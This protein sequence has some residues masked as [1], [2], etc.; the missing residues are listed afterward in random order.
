MES[1]MDIMRSRAAHDSSYLA[2]GTFLVHD[3]KPITP[4]QPK[5]Q[6]ALRKDIFTPLK[7]E[8]MFDPPSS[9]K[10][11]VP[12]PDQSLNS[13][14]SK[15]L[16]ATPERSVPFLFNG[17]DS[18]NA[19]PFTFSVK[20]SDRPN[21]VQHNC[22]DPQVD[23]SRL[24]LFQ[25]HYDTFTREHLSALVDAIP[26]SSSSLSA[27]SASIHDGIDSPSGLSHYRPAKRIKLSPPDL[28][29]ARRRHRLSIPRNA[30]TTGRRDNIRESKSVVQT[31]VY[32]RSPS[33][34]LSR[35]PPP[36]NKPLEREEDITEE[37]ENAGLEAQEKLKDVKQGGYS[38]LGFRR[39]AADSMAQIRR[40][41]RRNIS[42]MS[43]TAEISA[44]SIDTDPPPQCLEPR[45]TPISVPRVLVGTPCPH[46][47]RKLALRE[48]GVGSGPGSTFH[49][50]DRTAHLAAGANHLDPTNTRSRS[51]ALPYPSQA[52]PSRSTQG[53]SQPISTPSLAALPTASCAKHPG[54]PVAVVDV[55]KAASAN[56]NS[57]HMN[58]TA[59][60]SASGV[61]ITQIMPKDVP[62]LLE[63]LGDMVFNRRK[64]VWTKETE[65]DLNGNADS[66]E[67]SDDP[68]RDIE[69]L[70][71]E[72][73]D[74]VASPRRALETDAKGP[75]P[76]PLRSALK[77]GTPAS[78]ENTPH[79]F[80]VNRKAGVAPRRSVSFSDGRT[81][82][83]I[84]GLHDS[85]TDESQ[86]SQSSQPFPD[87][88]MSMHVPEVP[89]NDPSEPFET[90]ARA[91]RI[92]EMLECL[93]GDSVGT[94]Q[95]LFWVRES[96]LMGDRFV[97]HENLVH[98]SCRQPNARPGQTP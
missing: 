26:I 85:Q 92:A 70:V 7:L 35:T 22:N 32:A 64:M 42:P 98:S 38:F 62:E 1:M 11:Q 75:L 54:W 90:S 57:H 47:Q 81:S 36:F 16:D 67:T 83:R 31:I 6:K 21:P 20:R 9:Q 95:F 77:P 50:M 48:D 60:T 14:S 66:G 84:R 96:S 37:G 8:T 29:R 91:D 93:E 80:V 59:H 4:M 97:A 23:K 34:P 18:S 61:Q 39:Q 49:P 71:D 10:T 24:R 52:Q 33:S 12:T 69:S 68:F 88:S 89:V 74:R 79:P 40:D 5:I 72:D 78:S 46:V 25:F 53:F 43:I 51:S 63:R 73:S 19:F 76:T 41:T 30:P 82:G 3:D 27:S 44:L 17:R 94:Y 55:P 87:V 2:V 56:P 86:S 28:P 15:R 13:S 65:E 58:H 45:R